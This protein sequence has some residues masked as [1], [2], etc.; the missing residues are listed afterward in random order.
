[1]TNST[2]TTA[3]TL[4][5]T[6]AVRPL[7]VTT[8]GLDRTVDPSTFAPN[9]IAAIFAYGLRRWFQDNINSAAKVARDADATFDAESA[10]LDRLEQATSGDIASRGGSTTDPMTD[11]RRKAV[12]SLARR[13]PA[14]RDNLRALKSI[15][16]KNEYRDDIAAKNATLIDKL[17]N[18]LRRAAEAASAKA[19]D[20]ADELTIS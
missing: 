5:I 11:W 9:A 7:T 16:E 8:Q 20:L 17:A 6:I 13:N 18:E 10:F 14:L 1:M 15:A 2:N 3:P 12:N 19:T 4:A